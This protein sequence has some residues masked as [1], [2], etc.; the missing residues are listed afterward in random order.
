MGQHSLACARGVNGRSM[1]RQRGGVLSKV[2]S[3]FDNNMR[4]RNKIGMVRNSTL[5]ASKSFSDLRFSISCLMT[6]QSLSEVYA[7]VELS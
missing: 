1:M 2:G 4:N 7:I 5:W 3:H 6:P